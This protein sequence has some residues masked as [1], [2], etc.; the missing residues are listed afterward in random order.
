MSSGQVQLHNKTDPTAIVTA[1]SNSHDP[2]GPWRPHLQRATSIWGLVS[3]GQPTTN[4]VLPRAQRA[5]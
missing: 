5:Y 1:V 4:C 3:R 2:L